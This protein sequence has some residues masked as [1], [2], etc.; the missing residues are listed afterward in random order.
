METGKYIADEGGQLSNIQP[1]HFWTPPP[2]KKKGFLLVK[3]LCMLNM[4]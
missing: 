2:K 4:I 1:T 3:Q